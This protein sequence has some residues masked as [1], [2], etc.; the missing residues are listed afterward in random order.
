MYE[1][2]TEKNPEQCDTQEYYQ[3]KYN[4]QPED[5]NDNDDF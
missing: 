4:Q 2:N 3:D 1:D 5:K